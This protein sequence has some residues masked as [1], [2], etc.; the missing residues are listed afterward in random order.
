MRP[1][2]AFDTFF[3]TKSV[4]SDKN[5]KRQTDRQTDRDRDAVRYVVNNFNGT[6]FK[7]RYCLKL[8]YKNINICKQEIK[9]E[10]E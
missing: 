1:P 5:D 7:Y 2:T 10:N 6:I 4:C 9:R 8:Q 3:A